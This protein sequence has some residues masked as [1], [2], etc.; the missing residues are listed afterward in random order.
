[1]TLY[2]IVLFGQMLGDAKKKGIFF[3]QK[4][5]NFLKLE[6]FFCFCFCVVSLPGLESILKLYFSLFQNVCALRQTPQPKQ[7]SSPVGGCLI[8]RGQSPSSLLP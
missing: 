2:E 5:I 7:N 1:M 3:V 6:R 4:G 8:R